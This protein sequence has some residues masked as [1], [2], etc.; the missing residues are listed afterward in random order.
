MADKYFE[1]ALEL[2]ASFEGFRD[3]P[4]DDGGGV[5]TFGY[6]SLCKNYPK[7]KFPVSRKRAL[8][9]L[10]NDL[11]RFDIAIDKH[12]TY[13]LEENERIALLSWTYNCGDTAL[14]ISGLCRVINDGLLWL[15]PAEF[16]KWVFD[17][18]RKIP[19]L[20]KRRAIEAHIF[21]PYYSSSTI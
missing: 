16:K 15:A 8:E 19:G 18:G 20:V 21:A 4:Y 12:I 1:K 5:M 17:N 14:K 11:K 10:S 7:E 9:L 6:G 2:V 13:P 3:M